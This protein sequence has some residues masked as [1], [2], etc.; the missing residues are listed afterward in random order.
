[1]VRIAVF[2]DVHGN[3]PALRAALDA[4]KDAG[5]DAVYHLGDAIAIGPYPAECLD[6]LLATPGMRFVMG[7]HDAWFAFGLPSPRPDWLSVG[8]Y[9]HQLWTHARLDPALRQVVGGWP[10]RIDED[11]E[12]VRLRFVHYALDETGRR[13]RWLGPSPGAGALD[14]AFGGETDLVCFGHDHARLD[15]TGQARYLNPGALGCSVEPVARFAIVE[16]EA[17]EFAVSPR[18]VVY[19]DA[20]LIR[21]FERREVPE[22]EFILRSF[23]G[24]G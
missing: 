11:I 5:C 7:N 6:L 17:G 18:A 1:M 16:I 10:Y 24:R 23:F 22:R 8:E 21:E 12:G 9:A 13:F 3:L 20:E 15:V 14:A 19:D 2:T 4:I